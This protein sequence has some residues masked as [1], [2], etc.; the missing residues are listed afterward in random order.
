MDSEWTKCMGSCLGNVFVKCV[1]HW[2]QGQQLQIW[3]RWC[4]FNGDKET[5]Y[6]FLWRGIK[7]RGPMSKNTMACKKSRASM[8]KI[9]CK[10]ILWFFDI[11]LLLATRWFCWHD[12]QRVLVEESGVFLCWHHHFTMWFFMLTL[13]PGG[14]TIGL[15]VAA[16]HRRM[17]QFL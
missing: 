9:L 2:T 1:C 4:I 5:Q 6:T 14:W 16:V 8:N 3:P 15:M 17:N 11:F 13:S 10:A 7:A 12:W